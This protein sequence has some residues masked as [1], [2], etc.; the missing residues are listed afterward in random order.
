M[1]RHHPHA[2]SVLH[3][4]SYVLSEVAQELSEVIEVIKAVA[5]LHL[6]NHTVEKRLVLHFHHHAAEVMVLNVLGSKNCPTLALEAS[7]LHLGLLHLASH[8]I[9][10]IAVVHSIVVTRWN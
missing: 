7:L 9:D 5:L 3:G 10:H 6:F 4:V 2:H 1:L 8:S